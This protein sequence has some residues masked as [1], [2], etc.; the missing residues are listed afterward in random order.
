MFTDTF[1]ILYALQYVTLAELG[2]LTA[3]RFFVQAITDYPTG[4]VGDWI[5]QK[6]GLATASF[7]FALGYLALSQATSFN[8]LLIA[9]ILLAL[10]SG[11]QSGAFISWFDNNY[12]HYSMD[13]DADRRIY[14]QLFGKFMMIFQITSAVAFIFGGIVVNF[15]G[16]AEVF[17][18]QGVFFIFL[19]IILFIFIVDHPNLIRSKPEFKAYFNL[20]GEGLTSTWNNRTLRLLVFG[21]VISGSV[22]TIWGTFILFPMYEWYSKTD[23]LTAILRSTIFII[24]AI[25]TGFMGV[26]SKK[27][28]NTQ[29]WLAL[30]ILISDIFFFWGMFFMFNVNPAPNE[31]SML[32]FVFVIFTFT[33]L[34]IPMT[35]QGIL[36][37]RFMLDIIPDKNRNSVYSLIPTLVVFAS[38]ITTALGGQ[39]VSDLGEKNVLIGL[40]LIGL[41]G[42]SISAWAVLKHKK[43]KPKE[44]LTLIEPMTVI[45]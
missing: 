2:Y 38:I 42:A 31:F 17:L 10:A 30:T 4:A 27:I 36:A 34:T 15:F 44:K 5:G 3:I 6:W 21:I 18:F 9:F 24:G 8:T 33:V 35:I 40:G 28:Y 20:L 23:D 43:E 13:E 25:I 19:I 29:K 45:T 12:K 41:F 7:F 1:F 16:R 32:P 37:Q 26:L 22:M 14:S 39:I 11:Q